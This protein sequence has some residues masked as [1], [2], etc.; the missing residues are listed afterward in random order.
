MGQNLEGLSETPK[1]NLNY[2]PEERQF[3]NGTLV[4][5]YNL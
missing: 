2:V 4:S 5:L 1:T 3:H